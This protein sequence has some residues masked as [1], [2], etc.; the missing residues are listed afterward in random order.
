MLF[1]RHY[2]SDGLGL[3]DALIAGTALGRCATLYTFNNKHFR[4]VSGL[5]MQQPYGR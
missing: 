3:I 2:L 1:S 4:V 5:D